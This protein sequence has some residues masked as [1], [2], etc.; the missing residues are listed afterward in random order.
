MYSAVPTN[1]LGGLDLN[2]ADGR[3]HLVA[4]VAGGAAAAEIVL[5]AASA[6][7]LLVS[8]IDVSTAYGAT[9]VLDAIDTAPSSV[10]LDGANIGAVQSRLEAPVNN[11]SSSSTSL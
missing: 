5:G 4:I 10:N 11:L 2:V 6:G 1:V 3:N 8:D 7:G 9:A